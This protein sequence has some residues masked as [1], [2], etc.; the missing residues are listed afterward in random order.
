GTALVP[1]AVAVTGFILGWS[2]DP[3]NIGPFLAI[4][5]FLM[6][7]M[8]TLFVFLANLRI[9][10]MDS[11]KLQHRRH[12]AALVSQVSA[13]CLYTAAFTF[14]FGIGSIIAAVYS[15]SGSI[16]SALVGLM[17]GV[18][19]HL[20]MTLLTIL[21]RLWAVYEDLFRRDLIQSV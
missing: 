5:A 21:R 14:V 20:A 3:R 12:L 10:M 7:A 11:E 19:T 16:H 8:L 15:G 9:K 1:L 13:S 2:V 6:A 4:S 18:F 17:F